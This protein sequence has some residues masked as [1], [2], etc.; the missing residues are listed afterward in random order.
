MK[1][2]D[3]LKTVACGS[4]AAVLSGCATES[5]KRKSARRGFLRGAMRRQDQPN[6]LWLISED[7]CPDLACY[8]QRQV[9]TPNLDKLAGEGALFTNA[10]V[11]APVC[12]ASRSAFLTGMYQ[13]SIGAHHHR[14]HRNDTHTLP[15]PAMLLTEYFR[16]AGYFRCNCAGLNYKQ[17]GK[18][19]W[20]FMTM[21][22]PF[23]G[24]DWSQRR[25][26]QPFFAQINFSLT[27]RDFRRDKK[28]PIDPEKVELPPY[29]PDHPL[30]RR[31]WADYLE[32]IQ[33]LDTE[34]GVALRWL[35]KEGVAENTIVMYVADHG[36][37][38]VRDKQWLYEGGIHVPMII[39]W[40][41]HLQPGMVVDDLVSAVD[42]APTFLSLAGIAVPPS[43]QGRVFAN[44]GDQR[45][46][47]VFAARD[48]C[49]GT[50]DRIRCVRSA[51][52]KYIR[53]YFPERPYTQFNAY[54]KLQYP[55][56]TL[57]QV[58]YQQGRLTPA[59]E[60]FMAAGRPKEELY[61]LQEDPHELRNLAEDL[62]SARILK[63]H[64]K[65]LQEW[66]QKTGDQ[67][68]KPENPQVL[69]YW[70]NEMMQS[71]RQQM[72]DRGLSPDI[73]DEEYLK[74]WEKRLLG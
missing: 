7:T 30:A 49:D 38:H 74:W 13:T 72:T 35:E 41:G 56:L 6:I 2:R 73:S 31:D 34:I 8:G 58:L 45:Q 27:H 59:Q 14:S 33:L 62:K 17:P 19:D 37:P 23:D 9:K 48:R 54:K 61:D 68:E 3:F 55:M 46:K 32:S 4:A 29:Y 53:N 10:F 65:K 69:A 67:G 36:R 51:R 64:R 26:G 40:P 63:E 52:Y 42:W 57:M 66:I 11:T 50:V 24:T 16:R 71:Y 20:N 39:R 70:Q 47:Y 5:A 12:S 15:P 43:M 22:L 18:T 1:R 25:T 44:V 21:T 60:K 28:N